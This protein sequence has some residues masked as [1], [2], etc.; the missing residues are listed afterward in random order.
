MGLSGTAITPVSTFTANVYPPASATPVLAADVLAGEQALVNR[1]EYLYDLKRPGTTPAYKTQINWTANPTYWGFTNSGNRLQL[2]EAGFGD[3]NLTI[4]LDLPNGATLTGL[5]VGID[6][7]GGHGGLPSLLPSLAVFKMNMGDGSTTAI[8]AQVFDA[9]AD[10]AAYEL[11]HGFTRTGL[12]EVINRDSFRYFAIFQG[13]GDASG[14]NFIAN[15]ALFGCTAT[16]TI[17][18]LDQTA[19]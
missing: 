9:P 12:S 2:T 16:M 15:L 10:V 18:V 8:G 3:P 17:T 1:T 14:P 11:P 13:E 7:V 19:A 6:P 5:G 4:H